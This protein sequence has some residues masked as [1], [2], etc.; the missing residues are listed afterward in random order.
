MAPQTRVLDFRH[1]IQTYITESCSDRPYHRTKEIPGRKYGKKIPLCSEFLLFTKT[2][3]MM[4][5]CLI[6]TILPDTL[7]NMVI[8]FLEQ[9]IMRWSELLRHSFC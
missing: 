8:L 1:D 2:G 9:F 4:M 3:C 6:T 5:V 7:S